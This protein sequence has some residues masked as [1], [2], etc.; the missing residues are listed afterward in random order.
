M[1]A[2]VTSVRAELRTDSTDVATPTPRLSWTSASTANDWVQA[3]AEIE[4]G[5]TRW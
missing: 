1:T 5:E 3:S 2:T 4:L